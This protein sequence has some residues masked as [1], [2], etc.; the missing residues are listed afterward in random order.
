[1]L[2]S[3]SLSALNDGSFRRGSHDRLDVQRGGDQG[4]HSGEP[5]VLSQ[6]F[7][8][9]QDKPGIH[10]I[11][12]SLQLFHDFLKRK[13]LLLQLHGRKR[14]LRLSAGG[15]F[16]I[17]HMDFLRVPAVFFLKKILSEQRA[18]MAAA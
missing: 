10:F 5:S 3:Y 11:P 18:V 1:M 4:L 8:I 6:R 14:D 12:E 2:Q 17:N 13:S 15:G 9:V 7:Q 16:G